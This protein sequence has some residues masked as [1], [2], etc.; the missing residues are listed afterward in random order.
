MRVL[1]AVYVLFVLFLLE[2][3]ANRLADQRAEFQ[4][5]LKRWAYAQDELA[6]VLEN[7]RMSMV[8]VAL[9]WIAATESWE[10]PMWADAYAVVP[11]H[12]DACWRCRATISK[13]DDFGLCDRC[14]E[15][16]RDL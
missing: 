15:E 14:K 10:P 13:D 1:L 11:V 8:D 5:A 2:V 16:L 9:A 6:R 4:R 7:W 12:L 3:L